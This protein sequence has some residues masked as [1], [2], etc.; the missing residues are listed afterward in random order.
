MNTP[1]F[2]V[3][4][5]NEMMRMCVGNKAFCD[6]FISISEYVC[7]C[8]ESNDT[9]NVANTNLNIDSFNRFRPSQLLHARFIKQY[10]GIGNGPTGEGYLHLGIWKNDDHIIDHTDCYLYIFSVMQIIIEYRNWTNMNIQEFRNNIANI[11][12]LFCEYLNEIE[13]EIPSL[14]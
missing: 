8:V 3:T 7:K 2:D 9:P 5:M 4:F 12:N 11:C 13:H 10:F 6:K 14:I 1:T